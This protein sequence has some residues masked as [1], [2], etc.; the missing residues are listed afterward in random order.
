[1][2]ES[3]AKASTARAR[4]AHK[5]ARYV[6]ATP[7]HLTSLNGSANPSTSHLSTLFTT[8]LLEVLPNADSETAKIPGTLLTTRS[9][10]SSVLASSLAPQPAEPPCAPD[11]LLSFFLET[12]EDAELLF[13]SALPQEIFL[14]L[15]LTASTEFL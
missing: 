6:R 9:L 14:S 15:D 5:L 13:L 4:I 8:Q 12:T 7:V 10:S 2:V 1:M 11:Q 3:K